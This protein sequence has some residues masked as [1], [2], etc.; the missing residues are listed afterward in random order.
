PKV[1]SYEHN[2][3][4]ALADLQQLPEAET[5]YRA[6]LDIFL[7]TYGPN[8]PYIATVSENLGNVLMWQLKFDEADRFLTDAVRI[9]VASQG[10]H[11]LPVAGGRSTLADLRGRQDRPADAADLYRLALDGFL[12]TLPADHL[13]IG[14]TRMYLAFSMGSLGDYAGAEPIMVQGY[15]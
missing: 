6:A 12:K 11:I 9:H 5:H 7:A 13:Y 1:G 4:G 2:L 10:A 8:H 3:G 15:E 14:L